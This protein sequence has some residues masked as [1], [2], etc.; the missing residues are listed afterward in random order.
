M[1]SCEI[2]YLKTGFPKKQHFRRGL[3]EWPRRVAMHGYV[4]A[5]GWPDGRHGWIVGCIGVGEWSYGGHKW[6]MGCMG[7][8]FHGEWTIEEV[9]REM[10]LEGYIMSEVVGGGYG[11]RVELCGLHRSV[12]WPW[13]GAGY[14]CELWWGVGEHVGYMVVCGGH[15]WAE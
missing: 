10:G 7:A 6:A 2:N 14:K 9:E 12:E 8:G 15:G 1:R 3:W 5:M 11:G 13:G 4:G